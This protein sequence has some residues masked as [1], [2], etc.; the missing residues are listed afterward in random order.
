MTLPDGRKGRILPVGPDGK[1][2]PVPIAALDGE[3]EGD[4]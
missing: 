2:T 3:R 1:L 4:A